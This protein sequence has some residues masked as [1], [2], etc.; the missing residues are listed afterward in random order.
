M[1]LTPTCATRRIFVLAHTLHS[2]E[3][4]GWLSCMSSV[5]CSSKV[6]VAAQ[7]E[8]GFHTGT[9]HVEKTVVRHLPQHGHVSWVVIGSRGCDWVTTSEST[10]RN[11]WLFAQAHPCGGSQPAVFLSGFSL[12]EETQNVVR[13]IVRYT[14]LRSHVPPRV[15][16]WVMICENIDQL[17]G[18]R[19]MCKHRWCGGRAERKG[20]HG[21][22]L[23]DDSRAKPI[24][25]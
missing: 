16:T 12:H 4:A 17:V 15:G 13:A 9:E 19:I 22:L 25:T 21:I 23:N 11:R 6:P 14:P 5:V 24:N 8:R 3:W 7:M 18:E 10:Q 2:M 1:F 20:E